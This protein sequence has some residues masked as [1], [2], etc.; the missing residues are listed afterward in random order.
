M[1]YGN[2]DPVITKDIIDQAYNKAVANNEY[3]SDWE[4]RLSSYLDEK[5]YR[6]C[7]DILTR[8]AHNDSYT[9]QLA[10]DLSKKV[11]PAKGYKALIDD[12]LI[13]DGY[14][15]AEGMHLRFQSPFLKAWWQNRHP[16]FEIED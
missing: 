15:I 13:K 5:D 16:E 4:T 2:N 1:A 3:F 14:L 7:S 8:C 11:L 9:L 10:F 6:Y 12:V